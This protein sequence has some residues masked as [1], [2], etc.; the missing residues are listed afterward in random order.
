M[1]HI[2]PII[3]ITM[4]DPVGIGPEIILQALKDPLIYQTCRPFVLGD[5]RILE[6]AAG[7]IKN[8]PDLLAISHPQSAKYI[9]GKIDVMVLSNLDPDS[10]EWGK[11]DASTGKAMVDYITKAVDMA[12]G[13]KI[14][15][16]VT[17]PI[18]KTAMKLSGSKFT[19]HT[20]ML[21]ERTSTDKYAMMLAGSKLKVVLI[22]IH[23]PI[24]KVASL[25]E[26]DK[27]VSVIEL[28]GQEL[29]RRFNVTSPHIAVAALNPHAGEDG[30]FG[31]EEKKIIEPAIKIARKK[32]LNVSGPIPPDTLFFHAVSDQFD[33]VV[34]MYHDQG[35]IPFK[36]IHFTDGVNITLGLPII[37]TSV[38]HGTAYDIAGTGKADP[39]SLIAAIRSAADQVACILKQ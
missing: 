4:G 25:L 5:F 38:D 15:A 32:G 2:R 12:T 39:G 14:D 1:Q 3:G 13:K 23:E 26:T 21:A 28:T 36:M 18:N 17:C 34:C 35:L 20:E 11:P 22:T 24:A 37:R 30:L 6:S 27:I 9:Y 10:M 7:C 19:G 29:Y 31:D 16:M 8:S 33:A